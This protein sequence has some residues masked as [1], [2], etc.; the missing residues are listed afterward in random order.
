MKGKA[1]SKV[2]FSFFGPPGSGKGTLAKNCE[3]RLGFRTLSTGNL[4]REHIAAET[5]FGKM[6]DGLISAG[7]L[8]PDE[9]VNDMVFAWLRDKVKGGD[10]IIL[11]GYPRTRGQADNF[12][13]RLKVF[14]PDYAF[15]IICFIISDEKVLGWLTNRFVCSNKSCQTI[16]TSVDD[17]VVRGTC[18]RCG[19]AIEKRV[20]DSV[21][22]I[23]NRLRKYPKYRDELLN[24]YKSIGQKV[25]FINV[26][27]KSIE[28][29]FQAFKG[30]L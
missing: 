23:K 15:R 7:K 24:Y 13:K 1:A 3:K 29:V 10:L 27:Q 6:I 14:A 4:F 11:D 30:I 19:H 21:E 12:L 20:D 5:D 25:E 26:E 8:V 16:Y 18:D 9:F 2:I 22:V 28:Q 17:A